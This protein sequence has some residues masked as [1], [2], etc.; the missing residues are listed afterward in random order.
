MTFVQLEVFL[1]V[2][3]TKN[4]T[5]AGERLNMSQSA[6]SHA[7]S[8]LEDELGVKLIE[9]NRKNFIITEIGEKISLMAKEIIKQ[10]EKMNQE[11]SYSLGLQA[12][13]VRIGCFSSVSS[14]W[15]P[16]IFRTFNDRFPNIQLHLVE[17][18]YE[19]IK[20]SILEGDIDLGFITLPN[21]E[22]EVIS[23]KKDEM[24]LILPSTFELENEEKV[25]LNEFHDIPFILPNAGC[26]NL[27]FSIFQEHKFHP[28]IPFEIRDTSTIIKMVK[29]EIGISILPELSIPDHMEGVKI[30]SIN[31]YT[32]REI[33]LA[34]RS[35]ELSPSLRAFVEH[36]KD[37][38]TNNLL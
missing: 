25:N 19:E 1:M 35:L 7:M 18:T 6:V 12:G 11:I 34:A 26:E 20:K 4:F 3:K 23:L 5:K 16:T 33:G 22:F 36:T 29:E 13:K 37:L 15:I 17:G 10:R 9:R 31:P 2:L 38:V 27:I 21:H 8:S 30:L 24:K 32:Y 28:K 14:K